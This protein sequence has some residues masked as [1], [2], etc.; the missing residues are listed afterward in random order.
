VLGELKGILA[1]F[2]GQVPVV[3]TMVTEQGNARLRIGDRFK[4][5]PEGGLYAEL[6]ALLGD[7]CLQL[8]R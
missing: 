4:V 6:K 7:S 3:I 5:A 8:G 1:E 2:P